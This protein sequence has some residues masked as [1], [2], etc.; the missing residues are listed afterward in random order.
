MQ[1][2]IL[3]TKPP[4]GPLGPF[5]GFTAENSLR[6]DT[7][8]LPVDRASSLLVAIHGW[9]RL[10]PQA[11]RGVFRLRVSVVLAALSLAIAIGSSPSEAGILYGVTYG[12]SEIV[13]IDLGTGLATTV[14]TTPLFD[15]GGIAFDG[16]GTLYAS[17][18]SS[19]N[20]NLY[21]L[22]PIAGTATFIG[23]AG[24]G[25][26]EGA[27]AYDPVG[28]VL[29][30]KANNTGTG[31]G[32]VGLEL[33]VI[34]PLTGLGSIIGNLGLNLEA[35]V[36]GLAI[37]DDGTLLGFDSQSALTDRL[38]TIDKVTGAAGVIGATAD[39]TLT[40]VGGLAVDPDTGTLYLSNSTSLFEVDPLTGTATLI[41]AHGAWISGLSFK[42]E[43]SCLIGLDMDSHL[44]DVST[45]DGSGSD[46]RPT[47]VDLLGGLALSPGGT[48]YGLR[49]SPGGE[50]YTLDIATG[51]ATLVGSVGFVTR[52]GGL[53]FDPVSGAL[54]GANGQ[55]A[56]SLY[57][58]DTGTAVA[59]TVGIVV[60]EF[61]QPINISAVAFDA[62]GVLYGLKLT[63]A[64]EIYQIN[65]TNAVVIDRVPIPGFPAG[66]FTGG[67][68]FDDSTGILYASI[69]GQLAT[70]DPQTGATTILGPTPA[71]SGLEVTKPCGP[72]GPSTIQVPSTNE[73]GLI[74]LGAALLSIG[75]LGRRSWKPHIQSR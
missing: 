34:D 23:S 37:L 66:S 67:L 49:G 50:L 11:R 46:I 48:L 4:S 8:R 12:G 54:Y 59:T 30:S 1:I 41:G 6:L 39:S 74:A 16:I 24:V 42:P 53:D 55:A 7:L 31:P 5:P 19:S 33:V 38:L 68:E 64:P 36:S 47:G 32:G 22:D 65:P 3:R 52:E 20:I 25:G 75:L 72:P 27:L 15:V 73:W 62:A 43:A 40:S 58:I 63:T 61:S 70:L 60:D 35:D 13:T 28:G 69:N 9:R 29:Y 14:G 44:Y 71:H 26:G 18:Q 56:G 10:M 17:D 21:T 57:T 45:V 2:G 51:A